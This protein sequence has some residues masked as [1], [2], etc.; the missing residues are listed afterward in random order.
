MRRFL[1]LALG[2]LSALAWTQAPRQVRN[3]TL[4][5]AVRSAQENAEMR[6]LSRIR[7]ERART[8]L[9]R[10]RLELEPRIFLNGRYVILSSQEALGS[11][12]E[13]SGFGT[14]RA[15][16]SVS[17]EQPLYDAGTRRY[18]VSAREYD[19]KAAQ[20]E[21]RREAQEAAQEAVEQFFTALR[22]QQGAD[23]Q[24]AR[25]DAR[26]ELVRAALVRFEAGEVPKAD[27]LA[28]QARK[29]QSKT[30]ADERVLDLG[31]AKARLAAAMGLDPIQ[32]DVVVLAPT[33]ATDLTFDPEA[34]AR[35]ASLSD[36]E[37]QR[38]R[39]ESESSLMTARSARASAAPEVTLRATAG[40]SAG[41]ISDT[42]R[43]DGPF[44]RL[45]L[46]LSMPI[47]AERNDTKLRALYS[48]EEAARQNVEIQR[49]E[50]DIRAR[51]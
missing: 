28:A 8:M 44:L 3:V 31:V 32:W 39:A 33:A 15:R 47:G 49:R 29:A 24:Q 18:E 51:A 30:W 12:Q 13:P 50:R 26:E 40:Y 35:S 14:D 37:I 38:R 7:E 36:P 16:L 11:S 46:N 23:R 2:A 1:G 10:S 25:V 48:E 17:L 22:L 4:D 41:N 43:D 42:R 19:L 20:S 21:S 27:V 9:R 5:E 45:T 6:E 34:L